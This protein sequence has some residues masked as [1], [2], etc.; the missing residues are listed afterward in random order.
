MTKKVLIAGGTGLIGRALAEILIETGYEV[1]ILSRSNKEEGKYKFFKWDVENQY[2]EEGALDVDVIIHLAGAG[3]A[4]KRW[5]K[6]RKKQ[7]IDSRTKSTLLIKEK[8]SER[9]DTLPLYIGASA[10]GIYGSTSSIVNESQVSTDENDFMVEVTR[11]WE[12]AHL[13]LVP[14]VKRHAMLRIG[15]VL[16]TKG[17][18][19]KSIL[20]PFLFRMANYF[21][22][23]HQWMSWIHITDVVNL[24]K[25]IIENEVDGTYNAVAPEPVTGKT[26]VGSIRAIKKGPF[27]FFGVPEII[28]K[29][30][31]G[32]MAQTILTSTKVSS[33]SIVQKGYR[34]QF[35]DIK[36]ALKNLLKK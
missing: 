1:S 36:S 31:F 19:L 27:L 6:S 18:A 20:I 24:I 8:L 3:I 14:L 16:S 11:L 29:L 12:E 26:L 23:G 35:D 5:S 13:E 34:F 10:I 32:E 30:I 15:I 4:D 22:N 25:F 7:I 28:L 33:A 21:G 2:I 17:G 9:K